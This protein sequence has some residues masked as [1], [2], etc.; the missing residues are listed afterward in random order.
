MGKFHF[1]LEMFFV[2]EDEKPSLG[3][4]KKL[5]MDLDL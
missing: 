2:A 3:R 1:N 4:K 5:K